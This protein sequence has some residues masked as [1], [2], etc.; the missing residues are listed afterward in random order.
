MINLK[1]PNINQ[2][3]IKSWLMVFYFIFYISLTYSC[4][5]YL[6]EKQ[7]MNN[8]FNLI[9]LNYFDNHASLLFLF[10]LYTSS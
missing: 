7:I 1:L 4:Y 6:L 9:L 3:T 5:Y 2:D 8:L 10:I